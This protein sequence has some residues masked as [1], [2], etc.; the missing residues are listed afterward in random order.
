MLNK[1]DK[2]NIFSNRASLNRAVGIFAFNSFVLCVLLALHAVNQIPDITGVIFG[3]AH[4]EDAKSLLLVTGAWA[5]GNAVLLLGFVD[6][7]RSK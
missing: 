5:M 1:M 7:V 4:L 2:T 6:A 3:V